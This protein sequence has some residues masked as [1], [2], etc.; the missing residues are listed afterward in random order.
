[1][2]H[3]VKM[4]FISL[5]MTI[6]FLTA[7]ILLLPLS[8]SAENFA[9][10]E[11]F[12]TLQE[13]S[14]LE[15]YQTQDYASEITFS[16]S[17]E[18]SLISYWSLDEGQ[19][20]I[21]RDDSGLG[22]N[23]ELTST[24]WTDGISGS[25]LQF[26]GSG[27]VNVPSNGT[28]NPSR[29]SVAA[30]LYPTQ[31]PAPGPNHH[32][33]GKWT[34]GGYQYVAYL[35][36][37]T[38]GQV[39]F[40]VSNGSK[41]NESASTVN[42]SLNQWSHFVATWD[43]NNIRIYVNG[44]EGTTELYRQFTGDLCG[45]S[46]QLTI[47]SAAGIGLHGR[48]DEVYLYSHALS[49]EEVSLLYS[50]A[51]AANTS[52]SISPA[53]FT[54]A[55]GSTTSLTATLTSGGSP[56]S[57][58]TINW[59]ATFGSVSPASVATDSSGRATATFTS[60]QQVTDLTTRITASFSGDADYKSSSATSNGAAQC[61]VT[62]SLIGYWSLDSTADGTVHDGSGLG[63]DGLVYGTTSAEGKFGIALSFDGDD[64]V[65]M[66][67]VLDFDSTDSWT[68]SAWV[69]TTNSGHGAVVSKIGNGHK[70]Y[71]MFVF[72][73]GYGADGKVAVHI[74]HDWTAQAIAIR[75]LSD[76]AIDDGEWHNITYTYDGS[77][78]ADGVNIYIDGVLHNAED[79]IDELTGPITNA[80]PFRIG[81]RDG[82]NFFHGEIDEVRVYSSVLGAVEI[83][84]LAGVEALPTSSVDAI[85]PYWK[86]ATPFA[87]TATANNATSVELWY[88]YSANNSTWNSWL[89]LGNDSTISDGWSWSFN[90]LDGDGYYQFYSVAAASGSVETAPASA[91]A[92]AGVD[93]SAPASTLLSLLPRYIGELPV[94][95]DGLLSATASDSLSG[96]SQVEIQYRYRRDDGRQWSSWQ[97]HGDGI[98]SSSNSYW[99]W[100]P[101]S[102]Q[103]YGYYEFQAVAND[104]AGNAEQK[105]GADDSVRVVKD[106]IR[107]AIIP[108]KPKNYVPPQEQSFDEFQRY[109]Q[110]N[111]VPVLNKYYSEVSYSAVEVKAEIFTRNG[112]WFELPEGIEGYSDL[113]SI[114]K[115]S[116]QTIDAA[117]ATGIDLELY[118]VVAIGTAYD[119]V[120]GGSS[121]FAL[122][123]VSGYPTFVVDASSNDWAVTHEMG[124]VIGE[125]TGEGGFLPDLS[126][127]RPKSYGEVRK[128]DLMGNEFVQMSSWSKERLG[129]L[130]HKDVEWGEFW[131]KALPTMSYREQVL[132]RHLDWNFGDTW[133]YLE[134]RT[135]LST[136]SQYDSVVPITDHSGGFVLYEVYSPWIG[137]Q[138]VNVVRMNPAK[139]RDYLWVDENYRNPPTKKFG[140]T[141]QFTVLNEREDQDSYEL[142]VRLEDYSIKNLLGMTLY[143]TF[144]DISSNST[145]APQIETQAS[146]DLDLHAY[147][148]DGKHIG[149]NYETGEYEVE[150]PDS[151]VSYDRNV[152]REWIFV[153]DNIEV[154]FTVSSRDVEE[155]AKTFPEFVLGE[156]GLYGLRGAYVDN[157]GNVYE[158]LSDVQTIKV[159][160]E[161]FN[162]LDITKTPDN[163]YS[164]E[165][166]DG[167]DILDLNA[168]QSAI[169]NKSDNVF[170]KNK[171]Q[172]KT[173]LKNKFDATFKMIDENSYNGAVEKLTNDILE[174]LNAN[175]K[176]DWTSEPVLVKE[177]N[178]LVGFLKQKHSG[179]S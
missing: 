43:G 177:I 26:D 33:M 158:S 75:K 21:A 35:A 93:R 119:G 95:I 84:E 28:L 170:I 44:V 103:K 140:D 116:E 126:A 120:L 13:N 176:A 165:I 69:K 142:K 89:L 46:A 17:S 123:N 23:G 18:N 81:S 27:S 87:V 36:A 97:S 77:L 59:A 50:Q 62:E 131:V 156:N 49:A 90:A 149:M 92:E 68:I 179:G 9:S 171:N 162:R 11:N 54:Y 148:P 41:F 132:N 66:G 98:F 10:S 5:V 58:K 96:V 151:I 107:I 70:G 91:D 134:V 150:I 86:N 80:S 31:F 65:S 45:G 7:I 85:S 56:L 154:Y 121:G 42:I 74:V 133:G 48:M 111:G 109:W 143:P 159:G 60:P 172:Y 155:F 130:S 57:G 163:T 105:A 129:W 55:A 157:M 152:G 39:R 34:G 72:G 3:E 160:A 51:F 104:V 146:A 175:G 138:S 114:E 73:K 115:F 101:F 147:T 52:I 71:D 61:T 78:T 82:M 63:N 167:F 76:I 117:V 14:F 19:G 4:K 6:I 125:A 67:D 94:S 102:A 47:G 2:R 174:K 153:S 141:V 137:G 24:T 88:R 164:I 169:E 161:V 79:S 8:V 38:N 136:Y 15:N 110:E 108:A 128:W 118:D 32:F 112:G 53:S 124:H 168:W 16:N 173:S 37:G 144:W 83:A 40:Q 106:F 139:N 12:A 64:T 20:G 22:N 29:V 113:K 166:L 145:G 100:Q 1:M 178:A 127:N 99:S 30:W 25:A 122:N 135:P